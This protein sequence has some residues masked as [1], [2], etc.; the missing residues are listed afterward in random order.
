MVQGYVY[1]KAGRSDCEGAIHHLINAVF[2]S[3]AHVSVSSMLYALNARHF[4]ATDQLA[5]C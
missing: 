2:V 1:V 3:F 5:T 4:L